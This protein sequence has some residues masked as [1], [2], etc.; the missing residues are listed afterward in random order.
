MMKLERHEDATERLT[1][2]TDILEQL[3]ALRIATF[4]SKLGL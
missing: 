2:E 4:L 3:K 1:K